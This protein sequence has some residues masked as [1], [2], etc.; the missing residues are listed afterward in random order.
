MY[1][2]YNVASMGMRYWMS[3]FITRWTACMVRVIMVD[4]APRVMV[5]C[6]LLSEIQS[7]PPSNR[8]PVVITE[9]GCLNPEI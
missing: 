5:N 7:V 4:A 6:Q 9:R 8:R 2:A 3:D 1:L